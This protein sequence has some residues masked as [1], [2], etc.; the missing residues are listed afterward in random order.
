MSPRLGC[1]TCLLFFA[2]RRKV[3]GQ[4]L[5]ASRSPRA[6]T[7]PR[8]R[9][10]WLVKPRMISESR[11][12]APISSRLGA[13]RGAPRGGSG[14]PGSAM[15]ERGAAPSASRRRHP[16]RALNGRAPTVAAPHTAQAARQAPSPRRLAPPGPAL[17]PRRAPPR[18]GP[19]CP[20]APTAPPLPRRRAGH[21]DPSW[22][23]V[24]ARCAVEDGGPEPGWVCTQLARASPD[25]SAS[26]SGPW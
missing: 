10:R 19:A 18:S 8:R 11:Q 13:L 24:P 4:R 21:A 1:G 20:P 15:E 12:S 9:R 25:V 14:D 5:L 23:G 26:C 2:P 22:G 7:L 16:T 17:A 6:L 3:A